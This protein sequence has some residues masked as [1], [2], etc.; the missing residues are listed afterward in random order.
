M[1]IIRFGVAA[2]AL[3]LF[4][5]NI[6]A[7]SFDYIS[8]V[9][10]EI[11]FLGDATFHF[12]PG[13]DN[14]R[15][16]SGTATGLLGDITGIFTIGTITIINGVSTAPVTGS[17][18]FVIH[19]G[20]FN[21]TATL[22]W[23][24]ITQVGTGGGLNLNTAINLTGITYGGVNPDLVALAS[25][26]Q[27]IS[28]LTFQFTPAVSL[29]TLR[30]GPGPHSTSFSGSVAAVPEPASTVLVVLAL[31]ALGARRIRRRL[32]CRKN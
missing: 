7:Q 27:G 31:A 23:I 2:V 29:T 22:T 21:L 16:T 3:A 25:A 14:F 1:R 6:N 9:G 28:A 12:S 13:A 30:G 8:T 15:V 5:A 18:G 26:G 10:S 11:V 20:A 17:G 24:D 4:T 19:D 32:D